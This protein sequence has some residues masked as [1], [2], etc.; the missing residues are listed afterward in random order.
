MQIDYIQIGVDFPHVCHDFTCVLESRV[1]R[2]CTRLT[3]VASKTHL[4]LVI[5]NHMLL[6]DKIL[7]IKKYSK[8]H[9]K[10]LADNPE[11][12]KKQYPNPPL[13][14][15][16]AICFVKSNIVRFSQLLL[17]RFRE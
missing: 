5:V 16:H 2:H 17:S 10:V 14:T 12:L 13:H 8:L 3:Y 11:L 15:K 4:N 1:S 6:K 9:S 7:F